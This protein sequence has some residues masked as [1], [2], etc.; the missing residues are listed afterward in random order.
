MNEIIL[1]GEKGSK[2]VFYYE[3]YS[4]KF[5]SF[6]IKAKRASGEEDILPCVVS[7]SLVEEVNS[8]EKLEI[9][10]EVRTR[11]EKVGNSSKLI[12]YVFAKVIKNYIA[13]CNYVKI[14]GFAC[15]KRV[16]R[17][18]PKGYEICDLTI[19]SHR[20]KKKYDYI[21]CIAWGRNSIIAAFVPSSSRICATG[22]LQS[23][24]YLKKLED[25]TEEIRITY[26][27]SLNRIDT[28][29]SEENEDGSRSEE[30]L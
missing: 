1:A 18:T 30:N 11:N 21:P 12:V 2:P 15:K 17:E 29:E 28:V 4:E 10:G 6:Q 9:I 16:K 26:E 5:Y 23:R 3:I 7:E 8:R 27:V 24:E 25:K 19:A 13:D 20:F 22:R 14:E